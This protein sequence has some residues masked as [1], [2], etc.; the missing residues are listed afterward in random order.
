[1][2]RSREGRNE[3]RHGKKWKKKRKE[4]NKGKGIKKINNFII[5]KLP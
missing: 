1:M 2:K 3:G 4:E 5:V